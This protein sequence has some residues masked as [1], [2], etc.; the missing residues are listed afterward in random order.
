MKKILV[1][2]PLSDRG[3]EELQQSAELEVVVKTGLKPEELSRI[4]GEFDGLVVRSQTKVTRDILQAAKKLKVV[5]RAGVGVDNI[6]VPASTDHGVVVMNTPSGNTIS[7]AEHAFTLMLSLCRHIPQAHA[8][9]E[10]GKWDRKSFEG[11]EVY[12]KRLAILGMGR[13]GTE[14]CK[15]AQAFGMT[16]VA[17]DP[18]LSQTRARALKVELA[19]TVEGAVTGADFVT[20]HMPLNDATRH[21]VNRERMQ[22]L[23]PGAMVINCAR[24]GLVDEQAAAELLASGQLGGVALDVYETEPPAADFCLLHT[25]RVVLTPHLGASTSE[26]QENV[27]IEV[28]QQVRD[29]LLSG[30]VRNAINMPNLDPKSLES[31]GPYINLASALG[32]LASQIAP[33]Q[34]DALR[35]NFYGNSHDAD[36]DLI[37]RSLISG[38]LAASR[39]AQ[40]VNLVNAPAVAKA[41][42]LRV[43]ESF[44]PDDAGYHELIVLEIVKGDSR[45]RL[46]ATLFGSMP[47]IV[48]ID[49]H[50]VEMGTTGHFLV[51]RNNDTPGMVGLIGTL[52]G[53]DSLNIANMS[54][55]RNTLG[56]VALTII[57]LDGIPSNTVLEMLRKHPAI[58]QVRVVSL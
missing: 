13:I 43:T 28:A 39:G 2:D 24:G 37:T 26:A 52:L 50:S 35:V 15:R 30:E 48:E 31:A 25:P 21:I 7:T 14:F 29:F 54:L 1:A 8:S 41:M 18:F 20:L 38:Y 57:E 45:Y 36:S 46:A 5:G 10:A 9:I 22:L 4:I 32:K 53:S 23:N 47:R 17:Y 34:P 42:G 33:T 3:I 51:V 19:E 6:D 12:G 44:I 40:Q 11:T 27:G 56:G 55:S 16:V 58:H 49:G